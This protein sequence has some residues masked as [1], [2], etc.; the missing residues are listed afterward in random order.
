MFLPG[1]RQFLFY[2]TGTEDARGI[3]L[4]SL[5]SPDTTRLTDADTSGAFAPSGWLLFARQGALVA[6]RFDPA[7]RMLS[8]IL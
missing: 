1:G 6:R 8:G 2:A 5:D 4:G 3:Y 7:R